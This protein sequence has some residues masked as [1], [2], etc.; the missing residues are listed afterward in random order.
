MTVRLVLIGLPGSGKTSVGRMVAKSLRM[1]F[2][3]ADH[4]IETRAGR[5][6]P[7]VFAQDGEPAFRALEE[8]VIAEALTSRGGVLALGGGAVLSEVTRRRLRDAGVP[9]ILLDTDVESALHRTH[10]GRGRPLLADDP[11]GRLAQLARERGPVYAQ[12][13]TATVPSARRRLAAVADD[14]VAMLQAVPS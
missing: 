5:T 6:I 11:A 7:T 10:H 3:D 9:V 2:A 8:S 4:L 14:V 13:A 12:T 1:P